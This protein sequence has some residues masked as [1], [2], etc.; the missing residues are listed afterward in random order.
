[1]NKALFSTGR[2]RSENINRFQFDGT[3]DMGASRMDM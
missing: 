1:M 2:F 3:C